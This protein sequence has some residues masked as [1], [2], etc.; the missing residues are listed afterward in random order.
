[1]GTA[2]DLEAER[3]RLEMQIEQIQAQVTRLE[4]RLKDEAFITKAPAAVVAK[5]RQKLD[6]LQD[7]LKRLKE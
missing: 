2:I 5:Q 1:M 4:A 3:K 6:T 7:R